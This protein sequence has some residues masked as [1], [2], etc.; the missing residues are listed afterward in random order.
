MDKPL[1][2]S[3]DVDDVLAR[4]VDAWLELYRDD[5]DHQLFPEDILSWD[6]RKYVLPAYRDR[7]YEYI[8]RGNI[9]SAVEVV[10]GSRAGLIA[11]FV[12]GHRVIY[13]TGNNSTYQEWWLRTMGFPM[14]EEYP[15]GSFH[16]IICPDKSLIR[17]DILI[18]D[19]LETIV[20]FPQWGI[21]FDRP[22]NRSIDYPIRAYNW[23][24]VLFWV[25]RISEAD[26][27]L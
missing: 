14:A 22:W 20:D 10:S 15:D 16:R 21:L 5:S 3:V 9:Y 4:F 11:L 13:V 19:K 23:E 8:N 12:N 27:K 25:Q 24:E 1:T 26:E 6:I 2:I 7:I 18:D 17:A